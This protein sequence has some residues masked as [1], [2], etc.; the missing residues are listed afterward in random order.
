MTNVWIARR[1]GCGALQ[2]DAERPPA[3][4]DSPPPVGA[5]ALRRLF[6]SR[7]VNDG[8]GMIRL[9]V[10]HTAARDTTV[11]VS[12]RV[13]WPLI[14]ANAVARLYLIADGNRDPLLASIPLMPDV[15][16]PDMCVSVRLDASC[17]VHAVVECGDGTLLQVTKWVRL[18]PVAGDV[19]ESAARPR[20]AA[21]LPRGRDRRDST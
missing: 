2:M 1:T 11:P 8:L 20:P 15:V 19:P 3:R 7:I 21:R 18:T 16:P 4:R 14:L 5:D 9:D 13:S 17:H 10:P 6:G 12:I